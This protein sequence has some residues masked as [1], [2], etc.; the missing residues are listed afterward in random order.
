M[1]RLWSSPAAIGLTVNA[2]PSAAG[3]GCDADNPAASR[4]AGTGEEISVLRRRLKD[5]ADTLLLERT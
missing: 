2:S 3:I 5:M 1:A 4:R